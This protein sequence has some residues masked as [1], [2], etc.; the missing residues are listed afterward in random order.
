MLNIR[1]NKQ[2]L[3]L[4]TIISFTAIFSFG[5]RP[6]GEATVGGG[7]SLLGVSA[8]NR[9]PFSG[10]ILS[11]LSSFPKGTPTAL[12]FA[13]GYGGN[14]EAGDSYCSKITSEGFAASCGLGSTSQLMLAPGVP[15]VDSGSLSGTSG[16]TGFS[17]PEYQKLALLSASVATP[18]PSLAASAGD[19]ERS[20]FKES[21]ASEQSGQFESMM[22]NNSVAQFSQVPEV[23][24][25][26]SVS[27]D[28]GWSIGEQ[29]YSLTSN[30]SG[31]RPVYKEIA[32]NTL[33]SFSCTIGGK[34]FQYSGEIMEVVLR[35]TGAVF[36][37]YYSKTHGL[38][39]A[40]YVRNG[41]GGGAGTNTLV[42]AKF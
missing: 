32:A 4:I 39:S 14:T 34:S 28:Q 11:A 12:G 35:T 15:G 17:W 24:S 8:S 41:N 23:Y 9:T 42:C 26:Q 18:N 3:R 10:D 21:A 2:M 6:L 27:V 20:E 19:N 40:K 29:N 16:V 31:S 33:S 5:C 22:D 25:G 7:S 36:K 38:V 37:K 13:G 30:G 1:G